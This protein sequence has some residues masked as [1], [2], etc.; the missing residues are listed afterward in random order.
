MTD[1]EE[2]EYKEVFQD[3][4]NEIVHL[5]LWD[6]SDSKAV[7]IYSDGATVHTFSLNATTL[8]AKTLVQEVNASLRQASLVRPEDL[9]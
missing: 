1:E 7:V 6:E 8:E 3:K 2:R 5:C 4:I 9:N